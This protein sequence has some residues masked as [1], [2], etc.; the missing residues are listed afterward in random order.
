MDKKLLYL[1]FETWIHVSEVVAEE[2]EEA[3]GIV[4]DLLHGEGLH[5]GIEVEVLA[6]QGLDRVPVT[7]GVDDR[8]QVQ[9]L[10]DEHWLHF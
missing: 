6:D 9:D 2:E 4:V 7:G 10:H 5:K 1:S 3:T 8:D